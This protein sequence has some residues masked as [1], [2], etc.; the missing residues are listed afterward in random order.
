MAM[1]RRG[2]LSALL[3]T[4]AAVALFPDFLSQPS[5]ALIEVP[6]VSWPSI[7]REAHWRAF[8][9]FHD[10]M[11]ERGIVVCGSPYPEVNA[12]GGRLP[13]GLVVDQQHGIICDSVDLRDAESL[14]PAMRALAQR[15]DFDEFAGQAVWYHG[16]IYAGVIG[17]LRMV[18]AYSLMMDGDRLRFDVM[19]AESEAQKWRRELE[20][21]EQLKFAIRRR[22]PMYR[23]QRPSL[24]A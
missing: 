1:T 22:L 14:E 7:Y 8:R 13:S 3:G 11:L 9:M 24:P 6:I 17:P 2:F 10:A 16:T 15:C 4:S 20:R 21:R 18:V 12:L 19:G 5:D 23:R